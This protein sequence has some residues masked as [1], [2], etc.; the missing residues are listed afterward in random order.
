MPI[1]GADQQI[2]EHFEV[3]ASKGN[4]PLSQWK[5]T[6][7]V[8]S[9]DREY[10]KD[11]RGSVF[12]SHGATRIQ[13]P[14]DEKQSMGLLQP[15]LVIQA[16]VN[17]GQGFTADVGLWDSKG[18][19]RR[20]I[21]SSSF[22][23]LKQ[24]PNLC[25][26]PLGLRYSSAKDGWVNLILPLAELVGTLFQNSSFL[27]VD[28]LSLFGASKIRRVFTMRNMAL[29]YGGVR[30]SQIPVMG[31]GRMPGGFEFP[32]DVAVVSKVITSR[33]AGQ[34][35]FNQHALSNHAF[36]SVATP[37]STTKPGAPPRSSKKIISG[38]TVVA[39]SHSMSE[40]SK[41]SSAADGHWAYKPSQAK[42]LGSQTKPSQTNPGGTPPTGLPPTAGQDPPRTAWGGGPGGGPRRGVG[43]GPPQAP[44][45]GAAKISSSGR[46]AISAQEPTRGLELVSSS[47]SSVAAVG[48][49]QSTL[50]DPRSQPSYPKISVRRT[51]TGPGRVE[52]GV[53]S[54]DPESLP[55]SPARF[56]RRGSPLSQGCGM[57]DN[58][59]GSPKS[60]S[61]APRSMIKT[62]MRAR[63]S[64]L[65]RF[66]SIGSHNT[67]LGSPVPNGR[68]ISPS[69]APYSS[70]GGGVGGKDGSF[71]LSAV[72]Q[73]KAGV[74]SSMDFK[75]LMSGMMPAATSS[76]SESCS[77]PGPVS[78]SRM[79]VLNMKPSAAASNRYSSERTHEIGQSPPVGHSTSVG[80]SPPS[81][82]VSST[83]SHETPSYS[84]GGAEPNRGGATSNSM[85]APSTGHMN[86]ASA[87]T[88]SKGRGASPARRPSP[89]RPAPLQDPSQL[90]H[91]AGPSAG[92]HQAPS[93]FAARSFASVL[94]S[95]A[96][97]AS[98]ASPSRRLPAS[99]P[100]A[101]TRQGQTPAAASPHANPA[102][103]AA[104]AAAKPSPGGLGSAG[105]AA[106]PS[107]GG[108]GS[109]LQPGQAAQAATIGNGRSRP[110]GVVHSP[111]GVAPVVLASTARKPNQ[112]I[113]LAS[114]VAK[115]P[116]MKPNQTVQPTS[117]VAKGPGMPIPSAPPQFSK[118][119]PAPYP[120]RGGSQALSTCSSVVEESV[121]GLGTFNGF[122]V[123]D[124][125]P[126][127]PSLFQK[128][129]HRPG[130]FD[131][132]RESI[133]D[134]I[135]SDSGMTPTWHGPGRANNNFGTHAKGMRPSLLDGLN[136]NWALT[137]NGV[138]SP[139]VRRAHQPANQHLPANHHQG[140]LR[141]SSEF[142]GQGD[143]MLG[144]GHRQSRLGNT[145]ALA[146][147]TSTAPM[148]ILLDEE[149]LLSGGQ[150]TG[151][152][153][154][155][156]G[157]HDESLGSCDLADQNTS[158]AMSPRVYHGNN[159]AFTPP[160][161]SP[162]KV[163][164]GHSPRGGQGAPG[165]KH[166]MQLMGK[167]EKMVD[168]FFDPVQMC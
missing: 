37:N 148:D 97:S 11:V 86:K 122:G 17:Q 84:G 132:A 40:G 49:P 135:D 112:T 168:L 105:A 158:L 4:S 33:H 20:L 146:K 70:G 123:D 103:G 38:S 164:G 102:G 63:P 65:K 108:L 130:A 54:S 120:D 147:G 77:S 134:T 68:S 79:A 101:S 28:S 55:G 163:G 75:M 137:P 31:L 15:N 109:L 106:K 82:R 153:T 138:D 1:F 96:P 155:E 56:G 159:R 149:Y 76:S 118:P 124:E 36:I 43:G 110:G 78:P 145:C 71:G 26:V 42:P 87:A 144:Y 8:N 45:S 64:P 3:L 57:P 14:K 10:D 41:T 2:G 83:V 161:L 111:V 121:V 74:D 80:L 151:G 128:S 29:D 98:R 51:Q 166:V 6:G 32:P 24:T 21:V 88:A 22:N 94:D 116:G 35:D 44:S 47:G 92:S 18:T 154:M 117:T 53:L 81:R 165:G 9:L 13:C 160:V 156:N 30:E 48:C 39:A 34:S 59:L 89:L 90:Q 72:L 162:S 62:P 129:G 99:T 136:D 113:Q 25:Q 12:V 100:K 143:M 60:P 107:P 23:E 150:P 142:A 7:S 46:R 139:V 27:S 104:G 93:P 114:T 140:P 126:F 16:F 119:S 69:A 5:V 58:S 157:L 125:I 152:R 52:S 61:H 67:G 91:A 19:Q 50:V 66:G 167:S 127:Q 141:V 73:V 85:R 115:G 131:A 133:L 95:K